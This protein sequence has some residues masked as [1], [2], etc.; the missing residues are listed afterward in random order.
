[1]TA[2]SRETG[3]VLLEKKV[4]T[5][6]DELRQVICGLPGLKRILFEEGPMSGMIRD[7][8]ED[9]ADDVVS[10]DQTR[11]ALIARSDHSTDDQH[12]RRLG[13]LCRARVTH[14]VQGRLGT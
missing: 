2:I 12:A 10:C 3:E 9:V 13:A 7:T 6:R 5:E 14:P 8:L 1:M 11:S 4:R